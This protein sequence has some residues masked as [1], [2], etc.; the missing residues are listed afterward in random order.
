MSWLN[1]YF[2]MDVLARDRIDDLLSTVDVVRDFT[3][4]TQP[5]MNPASS[6]DVSPR[7]T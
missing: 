4:P 1:E 3:L 6:A 5:F 7:S 2:L